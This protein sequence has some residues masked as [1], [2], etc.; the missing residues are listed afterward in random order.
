MGG[1]VFR[2][3]PTSH[4]MPKGVGVNLSMT[5]SYGKCALVN[6]TEQ[7]RIVSECLNFLGLHCL[8]AYNLGLYFMR[9]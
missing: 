1:L 8:R 2:P 3:H 4:H 5:V 7:N 9:A 6:N